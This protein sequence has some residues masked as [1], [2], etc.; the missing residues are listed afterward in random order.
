MTKQEFLEV[1]DSINTIYSFKDNLY[2]IG[3][4][5]K[6]KEL[7]NSIEYLIYFI[8]KKEYGDS[9]L[10]WFYWWLYEFP[11]LKRKDLKEYYATEADGT[12][13]I[14][15]TPE[16]LYNFLEKNKSEQ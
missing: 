6:D 3:V 4:E 10:D 16:D 9:G 8:I 7:I 14:L 5:I 2:K 13:I 12:P 1:I 15:D 11:S